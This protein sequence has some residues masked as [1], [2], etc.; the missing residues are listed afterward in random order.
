M[1]TKQAVTT[2]T[3]RGPLGIYEGLSQEEYNLALAYQSL[4]QE[5][6]THKAEIG[7][8]G[9]FSEHWNGMLIGTNTPQWREYKKLQEKRL[10]AHFD[11]TNTLGYVRSLSLIEDIETEVYYQVQALYA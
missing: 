4:Y 5:Y 9:S 2:N 3:S 8:C 11:L 10:V 1:P 7:Y 6:L